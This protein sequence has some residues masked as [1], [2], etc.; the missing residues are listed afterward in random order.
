MRAKR[1]MITVLPTREDLSK[2]EQ[3]FLNTCKISQSVYL[4]NKPMEKVKSYLYGAGRNSFEFV[5][6]R[7][8]EMCYN[9]MVRDGFI[10]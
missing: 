10:S 4:T 2:E 6:S 1:I 9:S 7:V 8:D 3:E 5:L